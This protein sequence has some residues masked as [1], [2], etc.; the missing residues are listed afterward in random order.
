MTTLAQRTAANVREAEV[1]D[2]WHSALDYVLEDTEY[3]DGGGK[4][5][6]PVHE[7]IRVAL[8]KAWNQGY[9]RGTLDA[10]SDLEPA[11][12]PFGVAQ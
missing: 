11:D 9:L 3:P 1:H 6:D 10:T 8:A 4:Y 5:S 12:N 2:R 7:H